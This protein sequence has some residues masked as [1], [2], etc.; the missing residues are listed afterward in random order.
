MSCGPY[1]TRQSYQAVLSRLL[2]LCG[3]GLVLAGG[4]EAVAE[5]RDGGCGR[6][7]GGGRGQVSPRHVVVVGRDGGGGVATGG[8]VQHPSWEVR[9]GGRRRTCGRQHGGVGRVPSGSCNSQ[10]STPSNVNRQHHQQLTIIT[11][12]SQ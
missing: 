2:R 3:R 11:I 10:Q 9:E 6:E 12:N 1:N 7:E 8:P 4:S 5:V